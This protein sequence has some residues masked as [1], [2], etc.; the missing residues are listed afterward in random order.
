[1][2]VDGMLGTLLSGFIYYDEVLELYDSKNA[3]NQPR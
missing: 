2:K 3:D 1:M